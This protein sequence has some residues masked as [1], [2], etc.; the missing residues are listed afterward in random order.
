MTFDATVLG[1]GLS[2]LSSAVE[3]V[4]SGARI[5]LV[6]QSP[7]PGGRCYSFRDAESRDIVDNGQH[8][9]VG[10]YSHT[11]AYLEAVGTRNCLLPL[12]GMALPLFHPVRGRSVFQ[13]PSLPR[14]FDLAGGILRYR[15]ISLPDR[16]SMMRVGSAIH[17]WTS[18]LE[19]SLEGI[20]VTQWLKHLGQSEEACRSFWFPLSIAIMNEQPDRASAL[21]FARSM[22]EV[23]RGPSGSSDILIATVGQT[24]L[25]SDGAIS[26]LHRAGSMIRFGSEVVSIE[27]Q[28]R[29][30]YIVRLKNGETIASRCVV[31]ALPPPS[32]AKV[33]QGGSRT[34]AGLGNL[35]HFSTSPI[36]SIHLWFDAEFMPDVLLG[37][38]DRPLHWLFNRRR[39]V[40]GG[41][42]PYPGYVSC[43]IS[44]AHAEVGLPASEL[45]RRSLLEIGAVYPRSRE[46]RLMRSLVVKER[47]AT[48]S[49]GRGGESLR[50]A[51]L[52][53]WPGFVLAGDWTATGL[54]STIEGAVRSGVSAARAVL[55]GE[56]TQ[57]RKNESGERK[58]ENDEGGK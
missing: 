42:S 10:A 21:L 37:L 34:I 33:L 12:K 7:R 11:L 39:F 32:L 30:S 1:A 50:P 58:L 16:I 6:E 29:S 43:V 23:F 47:R 22:Y 53:A 28:H 5:A 35:D 49:P 27:E 40:P 54:P 57:V 25:Y 26:L 19:T 31:S 13:L 9:L 15:H 3:L 17:R 55:A 56:S 38:I 14:P 46:A 45:V 41:D 4:R 48:Y 44:G 8:L 52:T 18:N 24:E 36:I 20:S 51:T 2:G